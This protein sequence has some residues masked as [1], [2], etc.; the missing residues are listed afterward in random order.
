M[1]AITDVVAPTTSR[2]CSAFNPRDPRHR[3][4]L[5]Y[6]PAGCDCSHPCTCTSDLHS[7]DGA[8]VMDPY[9]VCPNSHSRSVTRPSTQ[10]SSS[11]NGMYTTWKSLPPVIPTPSLPRSSLVRVPSCDTATWR[12]ACIH[13]KNFPLVAVY[14]LRHHPSPGRDTSFLLSHVRIAL[15]SAMRWYH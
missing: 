2:T 6:L 9:Y 5:T 13:R 8:T 1:S 11:V 3:T 12:R 15:W 14:L 7:D 10:Y 4:Y